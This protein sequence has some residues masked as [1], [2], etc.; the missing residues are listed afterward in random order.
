MTKD[1][2]TYLDVDE[3]LV[4]GIR[5]FHAK[6]LEVCAEVGAI[7]DVASSD[8]ALHVYAPDKEAAQAVADVY[9]TTA[10]YEKNMLPSGFTKKMPWYCIEV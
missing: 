2:L 8:V 3:H 1:N 5:K 4:E 10:Q 7:L 6:G 9:G